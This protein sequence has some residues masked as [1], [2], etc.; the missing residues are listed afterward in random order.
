MFCVYVYGWCDSLNRHSCTWKKITVSI[1][2][3]FTLLEIFTSALA[4][5]F[6]LEF[7]WHQVSRTLLSLL[8]I[9]NN[10]VIW[11]VSTCSPISKSPRPF[12]NPS[13]I[14]PKAPI[15]FGT[16]DTFMSHSFLN[17]QARARYSSFFYY[18][19]FLSFHQND[20]FSDSF[21]KP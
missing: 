17:S 4:N 20:G 21:D 8:A 5:G 16:I 19:T 2:Y 11:I 1:D 6:S 7:E 13:V 3:L 18:Y 9:F 14:V 10:A 12:N 15:T